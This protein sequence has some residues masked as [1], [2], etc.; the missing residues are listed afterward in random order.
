M[1]Y[2]PNTTYFY[3]DRFQCTH[4]IP[5]FDEAHA[6]NDEAQPPDAPVDGRL[7][8][9]LGSSLFRLERDPLLIPSKPLLETL[10]R[11]VEHSS[12]L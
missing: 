3:T 1:L 6:I 11:G 9:G 12:L 8:Q 7:Q 4:S 5:Q 2:T 10:Q